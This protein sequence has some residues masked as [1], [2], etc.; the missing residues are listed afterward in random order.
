[1]T[2][3]QMTDLLVARLLRDHGGQKHKWRRLL[4]PVRLY[5]R[6]T[7]PHCNWTLDPIG[8]AVEVETIERLS[9]ELRLAHPILTGPR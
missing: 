7:H 1:M 6:A 8:S 4:G 2:A 5:D 3:D 9:D